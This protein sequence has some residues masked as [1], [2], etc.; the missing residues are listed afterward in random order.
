MSFQGPGTGISGYSAQFT[1]GY[2]NSAGNINGY[3]PVAGNINGY[4]PVAGNI[5]GNAPNATNLNVQ[6]T[7]ASTWTWAGQGGTPNHFWGSNQGTQMYVWNAAQMT[8]GT[9]N[10]TNGNIG[11]NAPTAS[12]ATNINSAQGIN[13]S[14]WAWSGQPGTPS[15]FWGSNASGQYAVWQPSI[16][17]VGTANYTNGN[18]GGTAP[19]ANYTNGNIGGYAPASGSAYSSAKVVATEASYLQGNY[20]YSGNGGRLRGTGN[21]VCIYGGT[22]NFPGNGGGAA[23]GVAMSNFG[24]M[25]TT[26]H[27]CYTNNSLQ[28]VY[29][30]NDGY[31]W[32]IG[33]DK[34]YSG[35]NGNVNWWLCNYFLL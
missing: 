24:R 5:N 15:W 34:S 19:V 26:G 29:S 1:V 25:A 28:Y 6:G 31:Q 21:D 27:T 3:A 9:A 18:I 32:Y 10:Y 8:I 35:E 11:G 22:T 4:A 13:G 2:A 16:I 7:G 30:Y 14:S 20:I 23:I 12:S 33:C 17:T